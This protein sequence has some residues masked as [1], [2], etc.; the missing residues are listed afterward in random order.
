MEQHVAGMDRLLNRRKLLGTGIGAGASLGL[1]GYLAKALAE[2][3][4]VAAA[5]TAATASAPASTIA[6]T[7]G[8]ATPFSFD[9]LKARAQGLAAVPWQ[10]PVSADQAIL[11]HIDYDTY[12]QIQF[13]PEASL[14][15]D[16]DNSAPVQLFHQG[17]LFIDPV[18]IHLV[19]GGTAREV[20]YSQALFD[21][22]ADHAARAL[23]DR[24]GFAGFRVM[25]RDLKNDWLSFLG[26]SYFRASGPY[27]QYGLSARGLAI[28]SGL[29]TP[30]EFPHFTEFWLEGGEGKATVTIY[31]LLDSPSISGAY[32]IATDHLTDANDIHRI[33]MDIDSEL[34][35]RTDLSRVGI[36]PFS[37]MF[38]Y[39]EGSRKRGVDWR[40]EIHDND[41]LA[42]HAGTGERIWR[43]LNNPSR[44]MTSTFVDRDMKGFGLLQRDRDFVHYLDD[45]VFYERRPSVWVE[46]LDPWGEGSV[47]L[48]EIP[49]DDETN[50]NIVAYW[51]PKDG[52]KKGTKARYHYKLSWLDDIPFPDTLGRATATWTGI[53][54]RPGVKR[55]DGVRKYVIDWQGPVFA[56][57]GRTDGVELI[58]TA[59]RGTVSNAYTHPVVDQRERWRSLF[60]IEATGSEPVD[61]RAYLRRG[62]RALSETWLSQ[63]FPQE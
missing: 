2:G 34:H 29:P 39:G 43:P 48:V 20:R 55:P 31:A 10:K 26:A 58:V 24:T 51:C 1:L 9:A 19:D 14:R 53:G 62:D 28:D 12:Q 16:R 59:S 42:I 15:V 23:S 8:E 41:G 30:E 47:H 25:A 33:V 50:D 44:V 7:L 4:P 17:H 45:G 3:T 46:P 56:G 36:A 18:R 60:D 22:P 54:G 49:T 38:W 61:I 57:L 27:N 5:A 11:E 63:Y 37:S 21:M 40:P 32:R 6:A 13:R 35:P 52:L